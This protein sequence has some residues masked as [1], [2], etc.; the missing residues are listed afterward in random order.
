VTL[1][2]D[3][4]PDLRIAAGYTPEQFAHFFK[5][6]EAL[7]GRET[8]MMSQVARNRFSRLTDVEVAA[9]YAYLMARAATP[10]DSTAP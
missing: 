9:I 6:G 7:G 2:G 1:S 4:G 3:F 10:A 5:T 8:E